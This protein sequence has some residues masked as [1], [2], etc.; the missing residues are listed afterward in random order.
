MWVHTQGRIMQ[1]PCHEV[2]NLPVDICTDLFQ[3]KGWDPN[4]YAGMLIEFKSF[5]GDILLK[6]INVW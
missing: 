5:G 3:F 6:E 4:K 1:R 2:G